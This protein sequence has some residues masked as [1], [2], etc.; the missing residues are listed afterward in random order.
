MPELPEVENVTR[1]LK[2]NLAGRRL[3][4]LQVDFAGVLGQSAR[5]TRSALVGKVLTDVHRH[6]KYMILWFAGDEGAPAFLMVHLRMT[7][8]FFILDGFIPD[9]HVHV[10]FDFDGL[11]VHYRDM[12][13][14]GRLQLVEDGTAPAALAHVG[15]D[16]M[17]VRFAEWHRRIG[18]RKAPIKALLLNQGIAAG[19]G[20]IYV[21]ESLFLA[22]V[23]PEARPC[24][25]DEEALR[26][27]LKRGKQV[28]RLAIKHGGTTFMNFTNFHGKPGNFRRKLRVYGRGGEPC[29]DCGAELDKIVV[30]GRGTVFCPECQLI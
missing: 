1:A 4:G 17:S 8:Q 18:S 20:N 9:K 26:E 14:F 21:D 2:E 6:G 12:R 22:G 30:G 7:G 10:T 24:D 25:L 29:R 23:H 27:V 15:P 11:P 16:M 19:L 13:K 5:K 28:M 3:T